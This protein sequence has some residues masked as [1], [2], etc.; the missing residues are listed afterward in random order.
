M[1]T[2][3]D[4]WLCSRARRWPASSRVWRDGTVAGLSM[5][6]ENHQHQRRALARRGIR[7]LADP[8]SQLASRETAVIACGTATTRNGPLGADQ[9][10]RRP[11]QIVRHGQAHSVQARRA[12]IIIASASGTLV[13]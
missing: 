9:E 1:P 2:A 12:M 10:G 5:V 4:R 6:A 3:R 7:T 11:Q 8:P 13:P